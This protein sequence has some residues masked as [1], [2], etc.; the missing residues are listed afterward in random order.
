MALLV[1][2]K[3]PFPLLSPSICLSCRKMK[4]T[5]G[6]NKDPEPWRSQVI[7]C[8]WPLARGS[9]SVTSTYLLTPWHVRARDLKTVDL[10][11]VGS[12]K[13]LR[14]FEGKPKMQ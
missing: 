12:L 13:Y 10:E 2:V 5:E 1:N 11:F 4:D 7:L 14:W 3:E 8:P 9:A 6:H